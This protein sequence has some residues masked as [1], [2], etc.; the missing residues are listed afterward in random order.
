MINEK[1]S[2]E[3]IV[4]IELEQCR[5]QNPEISENGL[6]VGFLN[7]FPTYLPNSRYKSPPMDVR[8]GK[9]SHEKFRRDV[10]TAIRESVWSIDSNA[11]RVKKEQLLAYV[12][13]L[14]HLGINEGTAHWHKEF[15][16]PV[17]VRLREKGYTHSGLCS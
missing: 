17:Y 6:Y 8:E 5:R 7:N 11:F 15:I 1:R 10:R 12:N 13:F 16:Y 3:E 2:M 14:C 9:V 4:E